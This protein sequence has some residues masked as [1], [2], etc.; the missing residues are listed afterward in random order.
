MLLNGKA[1]LLNF[2]RI[3]PKTV[4]RKKLW[5]TDWDDMPFVIEKTPT[6]HY[7]CVF[8]SDQVISYLEHK[9][10]SKPIIES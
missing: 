1:A 10:N 2:L 3:S 4:Q 6:G 8:D 7:E 5:Q 9:F